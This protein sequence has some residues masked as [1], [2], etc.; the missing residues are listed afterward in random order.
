MPSHHWGDIDFDWRALNNAISLIY[1]V[2][3]LGLLKVSMKE[4]Y[5]TVR[6]EWTFTQG[7]INGLRRVQFTVFKLGVIL[8][9]IKY[10]HVREEILEDLL[11]EYDNYV[12]WY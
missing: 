12:P 10:Y 1:K 4:K 9:C 3:R 11:S 5:G 2:S 6:Y 7:W 8:A